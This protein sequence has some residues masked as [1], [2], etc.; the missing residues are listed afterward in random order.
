MTMQEIMRHNRMN[1][2]KFFSGGNIRFFES[3]IFYTEGHEVPKET[4]VTSEKG[5][6][7]TRY[8]IRKM[9]ANGGIVNVSEFQEYET[10]GSA[11]KNL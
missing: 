10:L 5:P 1:G 7:G 6:R 4:F 9:V 8:T 3:R 2:Y 11:E